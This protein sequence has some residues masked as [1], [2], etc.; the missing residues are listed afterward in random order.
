MRIEE[1][2]QVAFIIIINQRREPE[3]RYTRKHRQ[4]SDEYTQDF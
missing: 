4:T 2:V 3:K 1:R